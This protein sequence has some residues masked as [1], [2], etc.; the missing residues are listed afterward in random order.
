MTVRVQTSVTA[1]VRI[2]LKWRKQV[3]RRRVVEQ[4]SNARVATVVKLRADLNR[5]KR[6][7]VAMNGRSLDDPDILRCDRRRMRVR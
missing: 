2:V 4:V 3:L 6:Y 7:I 5:D 1:R